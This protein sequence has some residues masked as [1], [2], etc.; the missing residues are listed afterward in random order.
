MESL[1][2]MD[3]NETTQSQITLIPAQINNQ[4]QPFSSAVEQVFTYRTDDQLDTYSVVVIFKQ[5]SLDS[6]DY[7][8]LIVFTSLFQLI[9]TIV[10]MTFCSAN[11]T[12]VI[13]NHLN[14]SFRVVRDMRSK[15]YD[16]IDRFP[17]KMRQLLDALNRVCRCERTC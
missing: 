12:N 8:G 15:Y 16:P 1:D 2:R 3:Y 10:F 4:S 5:I 11:S 13:R 7:N 9:C 6:I 17:D 14:D